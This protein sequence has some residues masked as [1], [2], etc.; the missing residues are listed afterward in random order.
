MKKMTVPFDELC[1]DL[2]YKLKGC[3]FLIVTIIG[4][5]LNCT[6]RIYA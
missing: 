4:G 2:L 5:K 1:A 6:F 3:W